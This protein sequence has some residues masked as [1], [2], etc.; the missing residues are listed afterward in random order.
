M[1]VRGLAYVT[2]DTTSMEAWRE[3]GRD[4][5]G[6]AEHPD[7]RA[8]RLLLRMDARDYRIAVGASDRDGMR[9]FG[10][11]LIDAAAVAAAADELRAAGVEVVESTVEDRADRRVQAMVRCADPSGNRIELVAGH[12]ATVDPF[13][14]PTGARFVSDDL[15]GMGHVVLP[16]ADYA[17]NLDFY[18]RVL[19]FRLSDTMDLGPMP[20]SFLHCNERHHT[21]A[22]MGAGADA[23]LHHFMLEV[24]DI[25]AVGRAW[26][27]VQARAL[28]IEMTL[29]RHSN[30]GMFSFYVFTPSGF[31]VEYGWGGLRLPAEWTAT[32]LDRPSFWGH[33]MQA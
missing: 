2:V 25:D 7:S 24:D 31:S 32:H 10:L 23:G 19:G 9:G 20:V 14:S 27:L 26:E 8:D 15:V 6:M 1:N 3:F 16:V 5:L 18:T 13:V 28:K 29:G 21:V 33:Q 17:A 22:V 12:A 30:D 11:E 4:V